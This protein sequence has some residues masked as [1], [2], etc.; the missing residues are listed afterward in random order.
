MIY[1]IKLLKKSGE[2]IDAKK[3]NKAFEKN[4]KETSGKE[5]FSVWKKHDRRCF[6]EKKGGE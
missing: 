2:K 1:V 5:D 6:G 3:K 4:D